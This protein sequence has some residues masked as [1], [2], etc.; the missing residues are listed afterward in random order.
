[1]KRFLFAIVLLLCARDLFAANPALVQCTTLKKETSQVTSSNASF[2]MLPTAGNY[3]KIFD[4]QYLVGS[5]F[6]TSPTLYTDNQSGNTYAV[7]TYQRASTGDSGNYWKVDIAKGKVVGSSGTYT[8][9]LTAAN[10]H[11]VYWAWIACEFSG[12]T[13]STPLDKTGANENTGSTS[14]TVTASGA[15]AQ[16]C[17]LVTAMVF[18]GNG[19]NA[20]SGYTQLFSDTTLLGIQGGYR[21]INT[22]ETSAASFSFSSFSNALA[23]LTTDK[24]T[25]CNSAVQRR[26]PNSPRTGTRTVQ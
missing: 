6:S 9:T 3:I 1:M 20:A 24:G 10:S 2:S 25:A 22:G 18:D 5:T 17:E 13:S 14:I 7:D 15:N 8:I 23:I 12:L 11:S 4:G 21:V 16:N 19:G 26:T